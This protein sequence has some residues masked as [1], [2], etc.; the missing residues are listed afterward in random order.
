MP[1]PHGVVIAFDFGEKRI[2]VAV[3]D[4][5]I[6]QATPLDVV[7]NLHGRPDWDKISHL[8]A[9][10]QPVA[11]VVGLPLSEDSSVEIRSENRQQPILPLTNAFAKHLRKKYGV[12]VFRSD[13]RYSSIEAARV[14]AE[15][16]QRG[17]RKAARA[18]TDKIAAALIL[19]QWFEETHQLRAQ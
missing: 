15:N 5:S 3:G 9:E 1:V 2:G 11:F 7:S 4:T 12:P 16:R 10:W 17:R 8:V 6:S 18:V 13:E 19:E 14:I